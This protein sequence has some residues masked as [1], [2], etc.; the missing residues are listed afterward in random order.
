[1][2]GLYGDEGRPSRGKFEDVQGRAEE[3]G[4]GGE[5]MRVYLRGGSR[6]GVVIEVNDCPHGWVDVP[7][8][9]EGPMSMGHWWGP[10]PSEERKAQ[11]RQQWKAWWNRQI[12]RYLQTDEVVDG[13][14]VFQKQ[15][16]DDVPERAVAVWNVW[17]S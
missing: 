9:S 6:D 4:R 17:N 15:P 11:L 10:E 8:A 14:V 7:R 16:E 3:N 2:G 13:A 12:E 5:K 1:M